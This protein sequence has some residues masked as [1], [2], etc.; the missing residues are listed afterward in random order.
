VTPEQPLLSN[1]QLIAMIG[2]VITTLIGV[3]GTGAAW[4]RSSYESRIAE[5]KASEDRAWQLVTDLLRD[6]KDDNAVIDRLTEAIRAT[7]QSDRSRR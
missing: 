4:L 1:A 3:I 5:R 2:T 7:N 6:R